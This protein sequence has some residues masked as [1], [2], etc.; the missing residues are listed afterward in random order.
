MGWLIDEK[1]GASAEVPRCISAAPKWSSSA[2]TDRWKWPLKRHKLVVKNSPPD[3]GVKKVFLI[4]QIIYNHTLLPYN[5][6]HFSMNNQYVDRERERERALYD[7][8]CIKY[9]EKAHHVGLFKF[10][11]FQHMAHFADSESGPFAWRPKTNGHHA[12]DQLEATALYGGFLKWGAPL[13]IDFYRIFMDFPL[14]FVRLFKINHGFHYLWK[15]SYCIINNCKREICI[16]P[17]QRLAG[18]ELQPSWSSGSPPVAKS[19]LQSP[20]F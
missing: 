7:T 1:S 15:P 9:P 2:A 16:A 13:S 10:R 8:I 14:C 18:L 17:R 11:S 20:P 5:E 3:Y 6:P 12:A 19:W 4:F